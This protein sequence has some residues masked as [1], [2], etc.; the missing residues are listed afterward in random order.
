[1]KSKSW[2]LGFF[3]KMNQLNYHKFHSFSYDARMADDV[4]LVKETGRL[5]AMQTILSS[6]IQQ[7][8]SHVIPQCVQ[9][10]YKY[11]GN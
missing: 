7:L 9:S 11:E 3:K 4:E 8:F 5:M 2:K 1:M 6:F 10:N